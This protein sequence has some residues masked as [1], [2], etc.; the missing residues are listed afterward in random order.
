MVNLAV[1][2][3]YGIWGSLMEDA[4]PPVG[5]TTEAWLLWAGIGGLVACVF[6][7][8]YRCHSVLV[9][10][11]GFMWPSLLQFAIVMT[12]FLVPPTFT[13]VHPDTVAFDEDTQECERRSETPEAFAVGVAYVL[14]I[15][16]IVLT[17]RLR[18]VKLQVTRCPLPFKTSSKKMICEGFRHCFRF[19]HV[20]AAASV[21]GAT[22]QR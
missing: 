19:I 10:Q 2:K 14:A 12:P 18:E 1:A 9:R 3:R 20:L 16:M 11:D 21:L 13:S 7:R 4:E 5:C 15:A 22:V 17:I 8:V 6:L